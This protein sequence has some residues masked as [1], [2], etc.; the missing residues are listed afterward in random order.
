LLRLRIKRRFRESIIKFKIIKKA[1]GIAKGG[2]GNIFMI[3][4]TLYMTGNMMNIFTIV[5]IG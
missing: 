1:M 5:I 3:M 2:F 4:F